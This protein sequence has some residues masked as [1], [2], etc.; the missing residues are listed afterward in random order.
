M[1]VDVWMKLD[2]L[3]RLYESVWKEEDGVC[4]ESRANGWNGGNGVRRRKRASW[5]LLKQQISPRGLV[6]FEN[7]IFRIEQRFGQLVIAPKWRY[8]RVTGKGRKTV[9][10]AY[11]VPM[12]CY[13]EF[14]DKYLSHMQRWN[15]PDANGVRVSGIQQKFLRSIMEEGVLP[16][17]GDI[18]RRC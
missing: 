2:E 15:T 16:M 12:M 6:R 11:E 3:E 18:V 13:E 9:Q 5:R 17:T 4:C 14:F 1:E 10:E 8:I 7:H